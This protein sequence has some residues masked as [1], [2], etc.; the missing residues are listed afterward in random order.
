MMRG[1]LIKAIPLNDNTSS[2]DFEKGDTHSI[3]M[4]KPSLEYPNLVYSA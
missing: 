3:K 2:K 4:E 1:Y